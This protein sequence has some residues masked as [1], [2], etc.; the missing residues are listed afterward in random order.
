M[1]AIQRFLRPVAWQNAPAAALPP[2]LR[3]ENPLEIWRTVNG[4]PTREAL[5]S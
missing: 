1:T 3:D 4:V 5:T 2:A